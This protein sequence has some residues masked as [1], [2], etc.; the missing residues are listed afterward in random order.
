MKRQKEEKEKEDKE[1][2]QKFLDD[3]KERER[4]KKRQKLAQEGW[5][6]LMES[7]EEWEEIMLEEEREEN[8]KDVKE[9]G[10][11]QAEENCEGFMEVGK[12]LE[13]I[14]EEVNAFT[15]LNE[16][17]CVTVK[18]NAA[19]E[20]S[21]PD[22]SEEIE[23][24]RKEIYRIEEQ[25]EGRKGKIPMISRNRESAAAK[26]EVNIM[27]TTRKCKPTKNTRGVEIQGKNGTLMKMKKYMKERFK[28]EKLERGAA[29]PITATSRKKYEESERCEVPPTTATSIM[30]CEQNPQGRGAVPPKISAG[31]EQ[32]KFKS[33]NLE[34][35]AAQPITATSRRNEKSERCEVTPTTA[36]RIMSCEQNPQGRGAV[37]PN[38]SA[39]REQ[40]EERADR[41]LCREM[42][43]S[44]SV[45]LSQTQNLKP[46]RESSE[47][48]ERKNEMRSAKPK[49]SY[50]ETIANLESREIIPKNQKMGL[51]VEKSS[52][53]ISTK[54]ASMKKLFE[55]N[56]KKSESSASVSI[57]GGPMGAKQYRQNICAAQQH[58]Q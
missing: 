11:E 53:K 20:P 17:I 46:K 5:K 30:S 42:G 52:S 38:I 54:I 6:R 58:G 57:C 29:Q 41:G 48:Y 33:E 10:Q 39:G 21:P 4:R 26:L 31:T 16:M 32:E 56:V 35:G 51:I 24:L 8:K 18:G 25:I 37:P 45:R 27:K 22:R 36:T 44:S 34:R 7:I 3:W 49:S 40:K 15:E 9:K 43:G 12:I 28:S 19:P 50:L 47:S 1:T 55:N 23:K 14:L 13:E 2:K